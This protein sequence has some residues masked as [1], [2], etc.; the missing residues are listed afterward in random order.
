MHQEEGQTG[1]SDFKKMLRKSCH[2][3]YESC[4]EW[5]DTRYLDYVHVSNL[6]DLVYP[7]FKGKQM[8]RYFSSTM[9]TF[10]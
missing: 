7:F 2:A 5:H 4:H 10:D 3:P 6:F 8:K 9:N 1:S